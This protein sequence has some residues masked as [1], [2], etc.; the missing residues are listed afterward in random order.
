VPKVIVPKVIVIVR[1]IVQHA[2]P[3]VLNWVIGS[4]VVIQSAANLLQTMPWESVATVWGPYGSL[5]D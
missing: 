5:C 1:V 2:P 4:P 3:P